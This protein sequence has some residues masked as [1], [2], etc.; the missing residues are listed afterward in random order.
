MSERFC[1]QCQCS[2]QETITECPNCQ[3]QASSGNGEL[4][5]T[6]QDMKNAYRAG[7]VISSDWANGID[8]ASDV[9]S[10]AYLDNRKMAIGL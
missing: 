6:E 3:E 10:P 9:G 7:W 5:Y 1:H 8:V 2:W 4:L